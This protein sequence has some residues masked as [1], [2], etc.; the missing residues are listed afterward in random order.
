VDEFFL[1]IL[2]KRVVQIE[3]PLEGAVGH[4]PAALPHGNRLIQNLLEGHDQSSLAVRLP[5]QPQ[6]GDAAAVV[7]GTGG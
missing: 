5:L 7:G 3:L 2:E 6:R 1:K 4:T